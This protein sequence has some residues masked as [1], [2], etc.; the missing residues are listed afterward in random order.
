MHVY[1]SPL[2]PLDPA[3]ISPREVRDSWD[4]DA[5]DIGEW[6][7]QT[8]YAFRLPIPQQFIDQWSLVEVKE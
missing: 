5:S 6:T 1:R 7:P 4:Y 8:R 2:R 3:W